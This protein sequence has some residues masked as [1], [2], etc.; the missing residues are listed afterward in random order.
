MSTL[1]I[2]IFSFCLFW[3]LNKYLLKST[4]SVSVM[5]RI[6]LAT[7]LIFT[8]S[9]HFFK[10]QEMI[11]MMP[12]FLPNKIQLVYFTGVMEI[13]FAIGLMFTRYSKWA[14]IV[15]ILF[16]L[17][18]LPANII[19]SFKRV[20]LGGMENGPGYLYFRIPLQF[21]F[22]GWAYYFGIHLSEKSRNKEFA[23]QQEK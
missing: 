7:M 20:E 3:L 2:L 6:A 21:L 19:G 1:V 18:I 16:L 8:G 11:Q 23:F 15:L 5:G 4:V 12:E 14:S 13:A 17:A 9:S 10:T 22:I